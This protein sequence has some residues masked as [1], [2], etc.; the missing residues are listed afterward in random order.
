MNLFEKLN[1][2]D[3]SLVESKR[4]VKK[5]KL[6]ESIENSK[7]N[8]KDS[9]EEI[10][11]NEFESGHLLADDYE[12][13]KSL[14]RDEGLR[15]TPGAYSYY[16]ELHELGPAGF[17]AEFKDKFEFDPMFIDE[18]AN[19]DDNIDEMLTEGNNVS[20]QLSPALD[21][22]LQDI[23]Q[24]YGTI[25]YKDIMGHEYTEED[26]KKLKNYRRRFRTE[27]PY[28]GDKE[29]DATLKDIAGKVAIVVKN[30]RLTEEQGDLVAGDDKMF[31]EEQLTESIDDISYNISRY[32]NSRY[33]QYNPRIDDTSSSD[34]LV[35]FSK[36]VYMNIAEP[37]DDE[38]FIQFEEDLDAKFMNE[39]K[40]SFEM[41]DS[42]EILITIEAK[43]DAD[44]EP[45]VNY[46]TGRYAKDLKRPDEGYV[47]YNKGMYIGHA[48]SPQEAEMMI[49]YHRS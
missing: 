18:Y 9:I 4:V 20:S 28:E 8:M 49:S 26:L 7:L 27:I 21:S 3:D 38:F 25:T 29:A 10:V 39:C 1:R 14:M 41:I 11:F 15:A 2:L 24:M 12:S 36:G 42:D 34:I 6:T 37:Y 46:K 43:L 19:I 22:F 40:L 32:I 5:K 17:Y 48:D 45:Y 31:V 44:N 30:S 33:D 23:A 47:V 13:F 16:Q 35:R